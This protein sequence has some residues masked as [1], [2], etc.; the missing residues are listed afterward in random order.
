MST[1][2]SCG[3]GGEPA[4]LRTFGEY[5]AGPS[6]KSGMSSPTWPIVSN[7]V[8]GVRRTG[9]QS[10]IVLPVSLSRAWVK[11]EISLRV[12]G[13]GQSC[14]FAVHRKAIIARTAAASIR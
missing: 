4:C 14:G 9:L 8:A 3:G 11:A 1:M 5:A 7:G 2:T 12:L 6:A 13:A 10:P